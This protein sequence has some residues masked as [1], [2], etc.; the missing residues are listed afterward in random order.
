MNRD[1]FE[2]TINDISSMSGRLHD[3]STH[4]R[5]NEMHEASEKIESMTDDLLTEFDRLTARIAELEKEL[6]LMRT[7]MSKRAAFTHRGTYTCPSCSEWCESE[8]EYSGKTT[9][10]AC[11]NEVVIP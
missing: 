10:P 11:E 9:C 8:I 2:N 7:P 3:A 6:E 1:K 5:L 4:Y